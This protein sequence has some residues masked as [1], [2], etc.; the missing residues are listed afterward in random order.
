MTDLKAK[1]QEQTA[2]HIQQIQ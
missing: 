2:I 1:I